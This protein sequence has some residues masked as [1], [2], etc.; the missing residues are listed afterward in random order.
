MQQGK[1]NL[2]RKKRLLR[3]TQHYRGVFTDRVEHYRPRKFSYGFAQE[4]IALYTRLAAARGL[5]ALRV[6]QLIPVRSEE[7]PAPAPRSHYSVLSAEKMLGVF[8]VMLPSWREQLAAA[9]DDMGIG[10]S[11]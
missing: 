10:K 6:N 1:R 5:S 7:F 8:G 11:H 3:Q 9:F 2:A 4:I